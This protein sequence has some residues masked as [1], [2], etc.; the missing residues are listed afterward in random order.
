MNKWWEAETNLITWGFFN[1]DVDHDKRQLEFYKR[2]GA[3]VADRGFS[4]PHYNDTVSIGTEKAD[5]FHKHGIHVNSFT[6]VKDWKLND[7]P[8]MIK[9]A[10]LHI[11][12]GADGVHFDIFNCSENDNPKIIAAIGEMTKSIK[13]YAMSEYGREVCFTGNLWMITDRVS[14][15]IAYYTDVIWA[16]SF[17]YGEGEIIRAFRLGRSVGGYDKPVWYHWQPNDDEKRRV[18]K[19]KNLVKSL[20]A[21]CLF[22]SALFLCNPAYPCFDTE[23]EDRSQ[24][25]FGKWGVWSF[26]Y[27]NDGWR[28][29]LYQYSDFLR[30]NGEFYQNYIPK[31]PL[32]IAFT[33]N[34][35][36]LANDCMDILLAKNIQYEPVVYG[37]NPFGPFSR[38]PF[39]GGFTHALYIGKTPENNYFPEKDSY[40]VASL[41]DMNRLIPELSLREKDFLR[42]ENSSC[43][44][45]RVMKKNDITLLHLLH[46][47]YNDDIDNMDTTDGFDVSLVVSSV[48]KVTLISPDS[49]GEINLPFHHKDNVVSFMIPGVQYYS[50]V[51][52]TK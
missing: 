20:F 3:K 49:Y 18:D 26:A 9:S 42:M 15:G 31:A 44:W 51:V 35:L 39:D 50:L 52:I 30:K 17:G 12:D 4:Y 32:L 7:V 21:S 28:K 38:H 19:L 41:E 11:D 46:V 14:L 40:A 10:C 6:S 13:N 29:G 2:I 37:E 47:G 48:K 5:F 33:P 27:I 22:E 24:E 16:E 36:N 25:F 43:V 8:Q 1:G 23:G 34:D 45:G